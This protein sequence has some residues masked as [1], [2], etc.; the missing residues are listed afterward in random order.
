MPHTP[1]PRTASGKPRHPDLA[2]GR[3]EATTTFRY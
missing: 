1:R 2:A 3:P